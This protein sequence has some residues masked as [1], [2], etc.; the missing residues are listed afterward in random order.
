MFDSVNF[1]YSTSRS[2]LQYFSPG[3]NWSSSFLAFDT[4]FL[5]V[6]YL[7]LV[8]FNFIWLILSEISYLPKYFLIP[9]LD[10]KVCTMRF[11]SVY[12]EFFLTAHSILF[13]YTKKWCFPLTSAVDLPWRMLFST[14]RLFSNELVFAAHFIILPIFYLLVNCL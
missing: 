1:V 10:S 5:N 6:F 8:L 13:S 3:S 7:Q 14:I 9:D 4:S 11:E 2:F 12:S